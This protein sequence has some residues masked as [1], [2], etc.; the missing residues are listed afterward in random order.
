MAVKKVTTLQGAAKALLNLFGP[1]G[2]H[3]TRTTDAR[4]KDGLSVHAKSKKAVRWCLSGGMNKLSV[5][6]KLRNKFT[7]MIPD[8]NGIEGFND[9]YKTYPPVRRFLEKVAKRTSK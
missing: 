8:F 9:K 2:E 1:K 4:D 5:S 3:W 7:D 6:N